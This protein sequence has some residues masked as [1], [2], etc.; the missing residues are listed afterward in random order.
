[1]TVSLFKK[2]LATESSSPAGAWGRLIL[3]LCVGLTIFNI[4]STA[5]GAD[6]ALQSPP[7]YKQLRYDEDYSYLRE[8]ERRH[9]FFDPIK[10]IRFDALGDYYLSLGGEVRER[11]E[12]FAN[13]NW[14][15]GPQDDNGYLLQRYMVHADLHLG[16]DVRLFTQLKSGLE[17]G[18]NGGARPPDRDD[19]DLNQAFIDVTGHISTD[20]SLMLGRDEKPSHIRLTAVQYV[21]LGIFL[22][23]A[24]GL[25][26]L[27]VSQSEYYSAAAERNRVREVPILAP[28][29]KSLD[30]Y[31]RTIVDNYTSFTALLMRDSS[32]NLEADAAL[33]AQG[34]HLD[35]KEVREK[36]REERGDAKKKEVVATVFAQT[37]IL[38]SQQL[39]A[40]WQQKMPPHYYAQPEEVPVSV[41]AVTCT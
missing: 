20:N 35:P 27:Q 26:R 30:R 32:R 31:G 25:W 3:R 34:L 12:Y 19:F 11:Y 2:S 38:N 29:G 6:T 16:P 33:I 14:G 23:L 9:D 21:V 8:P 39:V 36:I 15:K 1:M 18:R 22:F 40:R 4:H 13:Y 5:C 37:P 17:D 7:P 10:Y 41:L 24:Y 28:R